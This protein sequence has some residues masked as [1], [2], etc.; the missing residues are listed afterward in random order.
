MRFPVKLI[1]GRSPTE[2]SIYP[3]TKTVLSCEAELCVQAQGGPSAVWR[4]TRDI[5]YQL[6]LTSVFVNA[7]RRYLSKPRLSLTCEPITTPAQPPETLSV[8]PEYCRFVC[9]N[10]IMTRQS[11]CDVPNVCVRTSAFLYYICFC[12][13]QTLSDAFKLF[14]SETLA[15]VFVHSGYLFSRSQSPSVPL[16][17]WLG[18]HFSVRL[19]P[20][21]WRD[22]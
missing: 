21:W 13:K 12:I 11:A 18:V 16:M 1:S 17:S 6:I 7:C 4:R 3:F 20:A 22:K 8:T 2:S 15:H 19:S 5:I 9:Y 10:K 14:I